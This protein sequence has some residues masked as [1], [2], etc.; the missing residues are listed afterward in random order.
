MLQ[1]SGGLGY[2]EGQSGGP[3]AMTWHWAPELGV[4]LEWGLL[5]HTDLGL[6]LSSSFLMGLGHRL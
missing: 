6:Q 3:G 5:G 2:A 4:L 1:K